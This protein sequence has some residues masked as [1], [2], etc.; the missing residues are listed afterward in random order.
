MKQFSIKLK[1]MTIIPILFVFALPHLSLSDGNPLISSETDIVC[2]GNF[3]IDQAYNFP[4][5]GSNT[6]YSD[7]INSNDNATTV[8]IKNFVA[9]PKSGNVI[10]VERFL[11]SINDPTV[12]FGTLYSKEDVGLSNISESYFSTTAGNSM[13]VNE[14]FTHSE[15]YVNSE[16]DAQL[17][18]ATLAEGRGTATSTA[19]AHS[20]NTQ[21][22]S[23]QLGYGLLGSASTMTFSQNLTVGS[24]PMNQ[25]SSFFLGQKFIIGESVSSG[26]LP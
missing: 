22:T 10:E 14:V 23:N 4:G 9:N 26:N 18:H 19:T 12:L 13:S 24:S 15:T 11:L 8:F 2:S 3:T 25:N 17:Y 1:V 21:S 20:S 7:S 6:N 16:N 5:N